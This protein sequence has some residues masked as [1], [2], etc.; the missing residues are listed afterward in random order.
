MAADFIG[1]LLIN[2]DSVLIGRFLGAE[3]LGL[4]TRANVLLQRPL[5]QLLIPINS[6]LT[7]VLS[8]L[9][10]DSERY[11]RSFMRAYETMA[12]VIF[13]FAAICLALSTPLV[14][15]IL[16]QKWRGVIPLFSAF[17]VVAIALPMSDAAVWLFQSQGRGKEQLRNHAI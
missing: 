17:A 8:R 16:G 4:Y 14:L 2:S 6:V 3:P 15:V 1:L 13:S 9:Q 7:P 10:N 11:R 5:Q 12:L